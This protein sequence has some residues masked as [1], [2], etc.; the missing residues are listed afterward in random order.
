MPTHYRGTPEE[1]RALDAYIKLM[2]AAE[3]IARR[4]SAELEPEGLTMSRFGVLE[5]LLH[6]GPMCQ[7]DLGRKIL[8]STGNITMVVDNLERDG[9]VRRERD[10]EDRRYVTVHLTEEGR[11]RIRS[12]FPDHARSITR[13]M[14]ALRPDEQ[15]ELSRLCRR[16]GRPDAETG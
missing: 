16:L 2:R 14:N 3:T 5:A 6:L 4:V 12:V 8:K 1:I 11:E 7:K 13:M 10:A 15:E 9:L